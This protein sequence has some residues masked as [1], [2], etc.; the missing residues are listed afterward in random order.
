MAISQAFCTS[1]KVELLQGGHDFDNDAFKLALFK[2]SESGTYGA[3]TTNYSDMTGNSDE[4]SGTGYTTGGKALTNTGVTSSGTTA[5]ADWSDIS[6]TSST[7]SSAGGL[8]YNTSQSNAAICILDFGATIAS[9]SGT[10][11]ISFP[12]YNASNAIIRIA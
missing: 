6:W 9:V 1:A 12:A 11:V 7:I 10:F 3:A 2:T 8:I 5:Y 4:N